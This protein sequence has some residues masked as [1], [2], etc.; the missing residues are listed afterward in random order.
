MDKKERVIKILTDMQ[1][2]KQMKVYYL[3]QAKNCEESL[4]LLRTEL[5]TNKIKKIKTLC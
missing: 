3:D 1:R 5:K 4:K 2:I